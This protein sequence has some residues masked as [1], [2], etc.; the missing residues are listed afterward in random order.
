MKVILLAAIFL[1]V[2]SSLTFATDPQCKGHRITVPPPI[3]Y[4]YKT[5]LD[6]A[7]HPFIAPKPT[8]QRGPCREQL[9]FQTSTSFLIPLQLA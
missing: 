6:N 1:G 8:D 3:K 4:N 7:D 2:S 9:F 5:P